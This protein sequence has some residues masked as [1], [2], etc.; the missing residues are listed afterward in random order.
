MRGSIVPDTAKGAGS[1]PTHFHCYRWSGTGQDWQRL[2]R[3]DTLDLN[4]PDRPPVRTV[5]WLI[6]STRFVVAVHTDPGSARD[7]LIAE[8]EGAR[9][10]A[11]NSVPDWVSSKD[12]GERALR[13]IETGCWPSYSQ[14]LAG[15]VIMFWSVI[16]TDQPCH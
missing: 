14:W 6:K 7:W 2:E 12:R 15:G 11:L 13:A 5:D 4:S 1:K 16:G 8:W 3:T 10:K 9:G